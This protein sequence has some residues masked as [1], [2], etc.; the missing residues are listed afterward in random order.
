[1]TAGGAAAA[2]SSASAAPATATSGEA[3]RASSRAGALVALLC[4]PIELRRRAGVV[5]ALL[6]ELVQGL[7]SSQR[8]VR[9]LQ[10]RAL[11]LL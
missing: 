10:R 6:H 2:A 9:C 5:L 8:V 7:A 11:H 3:L 4:C 1:M